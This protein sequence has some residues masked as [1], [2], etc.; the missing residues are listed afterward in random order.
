MLPLQAH[1]ISSSIDL[2]LLLLL[3]G[4]VQLMARRRPMPD[5]AGRAP[6]YSG[7]RA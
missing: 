1:V 3:M 5:L 4:I 2:A 6:E 7:C